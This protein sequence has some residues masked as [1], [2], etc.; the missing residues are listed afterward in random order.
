VKVQEQRW[1]KAGT[2]SVLCENGNVYHY[3][4]TGFSIHNRNISQ[5]K[6]A[7]FVSDRRISYLIQRACF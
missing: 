6:R 4:G 3:L 5:V 2:E 7:E 1:D